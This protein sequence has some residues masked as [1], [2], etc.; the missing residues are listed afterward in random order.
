[1]KFNE[2]KGKVEEAFAEKFPKSYCDCRIVNCL[3][4]SISIDCLLAENEKECPWNQPA[5]DTMKVL[6]HIKLP[7]GWDDGDE[8]PENLSMKAL[9]NSITVKPTDPCFHCSYKTVDFKNA[10]GDS[11]K[12]IDTF[13]KFVDRLYSMIKEEYLKRNLM[14]RSADLIKAKGYFND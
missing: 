7:S 5:N 11:E 13:G 6:I 3:G 9:R 10:T 12:M 8:L 2:F 1:M 4:K 14:D